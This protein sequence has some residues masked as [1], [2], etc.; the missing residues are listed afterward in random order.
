MRLN[1]RGD[2]I[3]AKSYGGSGNDYFNRI[4]PT[5]DGGFVV[6]GATES[7]GNGGY[8][9]LAM[10]VNGSGNITWAS[11]MGDAATNGEHG[12]E[13]IQTSD[14]GYALTGCY[15]CVPGM[16]IIVAKLNAG[17]NPVW[18]KQFDDGGSDWSRGIVERNNQLFVAGPKSGATYHDGY[19][20]ALDLAT[21]NLNWAKEYDLNPLNDGF[22]SLDVTTD[23]FVMSI[24]HS[25][26]YNPPHTSVMMVT[27]SL[28]NVEWLR[29]LNVPG[30]DWVSYDIH[31][32]QDGGFI[33]AVYDYANDADMVLVKTDANGNAEWSWGYG[34]TGGDHVYTVQQMFNQ[35]FLAAGF[36]DSYGS[37]NTDVYLVK[38]SMVG[39]TPGC[40]IDTLGIV[41]DTIAVNVSNL[42]WASIT[43]PSF[44]QFVLPD[45]TNFL[46]ATDTICEN[47]C[48][49]DCGNGFDDDEDGLVDCADPDCNCCDNISF[50]LGPDMEICEDGIFVLEAGS[51]FVSYLWQ[52]GSTDSTITVWLPGNY[53]CTVVDSCNNVYTDTM[54]IILDVTTVD[55]SLDTSVCIN[56]SVILAAPAGFVS[57]SWQ[58]DYF[59]S[60]DTCE[61]TTVYPPVDT[62]YIVLVENSDGCVS[63]AEYEVAVVEPSVFNLLPPDTV[64]CFGDEVTLVP[65]HTAGIEWFDGSTE[66]TYT[67]SDSGI[68]WLKV[69]TVCG[70]VTDTIRIS[71]NYCDCRVWVP[72]AFTPNSD[73]RNDVF[74]IQ[75]HCP[76]EDYLLRIY[77]RWGEKVF[78]TPNPSEFWDGTWQ[79]KPQD[80]AVFVWYIRY[81]DPFTD[82]HHL[83]KGNVTLLR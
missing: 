76:T 61:F 35:D 80:M 82:L 56:D 81:H 12:Y 41:A 63:T 29:A 23:G 44:H 43:S 7:Y 33:Q 68:Y 38:T 69:N 45:T 67:T 3:W 46:F 53:W 37:G 31:Q 55:L 5:N 11:T 54:S 50:D 64:I 14:G 72:N 22:Q 66:D 75:V 15:D 42:N 62:T 16:D 32:T 79:G 27:D 8:D 20:M 19:L 48:V 58:P 52:N 74:T 28:G 71:N 70:E 59:I 17:G 39:E 30:N 47:F 57:Y 10:K 36:T 6:V 13:I 34:G 40:P 18:V 1:A 4:T 60:C 51:G 2:I 49:E 78:E 21:G 73:G 65:D 77:N 25:P 83:L 24:P 26:D 9:L